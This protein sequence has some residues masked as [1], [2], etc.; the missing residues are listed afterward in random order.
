[1]N[2]VLAAGGTGGHMVPAHALAAELKAPRPRRAADHRRPR[3][4]LPRPVQGRAGAHPARR[5][6]WRRADRLAEGRGSVLEGPGRGEAALSRAPAR[7]GGRLW[8]LSGFPVA[9]RGERAAASRPCCTSRMRCWAGS[10]GCSPARPRRSAQLMTEV[11]RLKPRYARQDGAGRQSGSRGDR[12]SLA[13]CRSRRS[14]RS[15]R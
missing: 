8:R 5:P 2:F 6:A 13:S 3:R 10:T 15:R 14:T 11:D 9:A 12:A 1:M 7:R 4:A